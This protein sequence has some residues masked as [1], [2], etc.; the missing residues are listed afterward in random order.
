MNTD[1][2]NFLEKIRALGEPVKR[3]IMIAATLGS[4]VLVVYLWLAYFNTIVPSAVSAPASPVA[5]AASP[6]AG[7]PGIT[8]LFAD[9]ASSFWQA[10]LNGMRNITDAIR[11]SKQ[12][13]VSPK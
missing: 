5:Q 2:E 7:G 9:T 6:D 11:N 4:M 13:N 8:G 10:A 1:Q 12:Y 3:K